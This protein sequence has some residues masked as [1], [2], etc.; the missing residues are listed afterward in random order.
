MSGVSN[1]NQIKAVTVTL[2]VLPRA[3]KS[4]YGQR[5]SHNADPPTLEGVLCWVAN[6]KGPQKGALLIWCPGEDLN[7][8]WNIDLQADQAIDSH[9]SSIA[10]IHKKQ[11]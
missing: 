11:Q 7:R 5:G 8:A 10:Q 2:V 3:R 1:Y 6:K 4:S 9:F